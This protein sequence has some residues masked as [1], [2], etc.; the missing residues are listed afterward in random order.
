MKTFAL[1]ATIAAGVLLTTG[2]ADAQYRYR[3][4]YGYSAPVYRYPANNYSA[5]LVY[6]SGVVTSGYAPYTTSSMVAPVSGYSPYYA[7]PY[8]YPAGGVVTPYPPYYSSFNS[9][10]YV[11]PTVGVYRGRGYRW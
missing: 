5:P 8:T 9:G 4:G 10:V 2:P 3:N 1:A 7:S 6:S 11:A